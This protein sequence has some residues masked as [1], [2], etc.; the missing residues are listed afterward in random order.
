MLAQFLAFQVGCA[1]TKW[2]LLENQ[3][4]GVNQLNVL[5]EVVKLV[6]SLACVQFARGYFGIIRT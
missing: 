6:V 1:H 4:D 3:E 5:S 2:L